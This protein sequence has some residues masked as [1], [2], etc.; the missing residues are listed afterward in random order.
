MSDDDFARHCRSLE[1]MYTHAAVN[2]YFA[3]SLRVDDGEATV[4]MTVRPDFF[5]AAHAVHGAIFFKALD[6]AAYFAASSAVRDV[7]ILTVTFNTTFLRPV[8]KGSLT[9]TGRLMHQT[10]TLL[11][12]ESELAD[13]RGRAI[14][15]GSGTFM[16]SKIPLSP[17]VGYE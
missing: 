13:E 14:A 3:P 17:A 6:D 5:H 16:L 1:R 15:R 11:V 10:R 2:E 12:A 7:F 8:T 9:A 4:T